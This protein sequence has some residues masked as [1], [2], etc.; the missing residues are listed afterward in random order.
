MRREQVD[1]NW[2]ILSL[3]AFKPDL[4]PAEMQIGQTYCSG[5]CMPPGAIGRLL[6]WTKLCSFTPD[7]IRP[8]KQ[9]PASVRYHNHLF[10]TPEDYHLCYLIR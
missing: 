9:R 2:Y 10:P 1:L 7:G 5:G 8:D 3:A 4:V 6:D